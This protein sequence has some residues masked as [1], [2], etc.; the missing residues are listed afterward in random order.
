MM[1]R[2]CNQV[3]ISAPT[4]SSPVNAYHS[5][6]ATAPPRSTEDAEPSIY[7]ILLALYLAPPP[8]NK[9]NWPPA[10]DLLSK[11]GARLPAST[12]LDLIPPTLPVK[13]L[14]SYFFGRIRSANSTL[15]EERIVARLRGVEKAAIEAVVLLGDGKVDKFGH[16]VAGGLNRRVVID[17]DRHCAVCHKRFGGSA[18]R[19]YPDNSVVHSGCQRGSLGM[20]R[21]RSGGA[22]RGW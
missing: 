20:G 11:H 13:D 2:Y 3:Y 17:Q 8:P 12:T 7:H 15:N 19:V 4:P 14:E 21:V 6:T 1:D 16:S 5:T 22:S 18:I 10:L 9:P